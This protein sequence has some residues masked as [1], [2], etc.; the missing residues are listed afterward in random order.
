MPELAHELDALD[1]NFDLP[2]LQEVLTSAIL[3]LD[4]QVW[5]FIDAVDECREGDVLELIEFLDGLQDAKLY[6]CFASRHYPIFKVPTKLQLVLE[7][8]DEHRQDLSTYVEKLDLEGGELVQMQHDIIAKSNGIFLWVVLVVKILQDDVGRARF[9]AMQ[10]TLRKMPKELPDLFKTIILRDDKHKDEFLLCLRWILYAWRPMTLKEW[11]FAMMAGVD[12]RLE[13]A[14]GVTDHRMETFLLSSSK[15]LAELTKGKTITAQFIHESVRDYLIHQGGLEEICDNRDSLQSL[16][17]EQLKQCCLRGVTF[18]LPK[19]LEQHRNKKELLT[20][21]ERRSLMAGYPF[22]EYATKYILHHANG[23]A[24]DISQREF[25]TNEFVISD[26]LDRSN[27][28][29]KSKPNIY[30][31]IPSLCY[32]CAERNL[33]NLVARPTDAISPDS[34]QRYQTPLVTAIMQSNWEVLRVFFEDMNVSDVEETIIEVA[35]KSKLTVSPTPL[36]SIQW[37]WAV[38]NG[39]ER[40]SKH[41]L[42]PGSEVELNYWSDLYGHGT[43]ERASMMSVEKVV[44]ILIDTGAKINSGFY[45]SVLLVASGA[46]CEKV[47]HLLLDVGADV[48]WR[49]GGRNNALEAASTGGHV[50]IVQTL[51]DAGAN[52][53]PRDGWPGALHVASSLGHEEVVRMLIDAGAD[54]NAKEGVSGSVLRGASDNGHEK[55]VRMLLDAGAVVNAHGEEHSALHGASF[56]N[57][58][59]VVQILLDAGADIDA[60][61]GAIGSSLQAASVRGYEKV[62]ETLIAAGADVNAQGGAYGNALQAASTEGYEKVV[63]MLIDAGADVNAQG[64]IFGNALQAASQGGHAPV[65]AEVREYEIVVQMLIDAGADV[66]ALGGKYGNA[67]QAASTKGRTRISHILIDAG[68]DEN[69]CFREGGL[70]E[71]CKPL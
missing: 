23:A 5:L 61:G 42:T 48:N 58:E 34:K 55:I 68:A 17:H 6:V 45:G 33:A 59:K 9:H 19:R 52:L 63:Q 71:Y 64:G 24:V 31:D 26:W 16:A 15:G 35:S 54:V 12:G 30:S 2:Q 14:E 29:Q 46:G 7:E 44:Q 50:C 3:G 32:L 8:V 18:D 22:A 10:S 51:I 43:F 47:V 60:Q 1:T 39:L 49:E 21:D 37:R 66:N 53:D 62:V 69:I 40:L 67:L 38:R 27:A 41:F 70:V 65:Y 36:L 13:W 20:G 28:F 25:L 11:Y 57:H 56:G 4:R